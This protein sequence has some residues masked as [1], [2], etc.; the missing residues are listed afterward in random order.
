VPLAEVHD[1]CCIAIEQKGG[2]VTSRAPVRGSRVENG[3]VAAVQFDNA[4]EESA[5]AYV[6]ALP[7]TA[8]ANLLP[9]EIKSANPTLASLDKIK[10]SPITVVHFWFDRTVTCAPFITLLV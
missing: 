7:H 8:L 2:E 5:D 6:F 1:G 3:A 4:R 10:V 9:P